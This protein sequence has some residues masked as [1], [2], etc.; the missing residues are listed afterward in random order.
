[1]CCAVQ[2]DTYPND[3]AEVTL[4]E[5]STLQ[6]AMAPFTLT[7]RMRVWLVEPTVL[8]VTSAAVQPLAICP[9]LWELFTV[10][11]AFTNIRSMAPLLAVNR[12]R[13]RLSSWPLA[14]ALAVK[15]LLAGYA[16]GLLTVK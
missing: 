9:K 14:V 15:V 12:T 1:M 8:A 10:L 11:L 6:I 2:P 7:H 13:V 5:S 3:T 16:V 4:K